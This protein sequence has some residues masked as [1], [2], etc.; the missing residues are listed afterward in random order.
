M[1]L[2][3]S[4]HNSLKIYLVKFLYVLGFNMDHKSIKAIKPYIRE[5]RAKEKIFALRVMQQ[6]HLKAFVIFP[7]DFFHYL[8]KDCIIFLHVPGIFNTCRVR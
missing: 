4:F 5:M 3:C 1:D 8:E 6:I 7:V 2:F